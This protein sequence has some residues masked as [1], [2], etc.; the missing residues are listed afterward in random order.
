MDDKFLSKAGLLHFMQ[1]ISGLFTKLTDFNSHK[2]DTTT[3]TSATDKS[4]LSSAYEHS[5]LS[6]A[7]SNAQQNVIEN[8]SID[9]VNQSISNK[10]VNLPAYPTTL[11]PTEH[12]HEINEVDGLQNE[13]SSKVNKNHGVENAGK[14][15]SI[16][17]DGNVELSDAPSGG[18]GGTSVEIVR[19]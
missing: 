13:L 6:H 19:W 17:N 8:I 16:G 7:P 4:H 12:S 10:T 14:I 9:G 3:H 2:N 18:T 5:Q 1:R 15:L 11:P